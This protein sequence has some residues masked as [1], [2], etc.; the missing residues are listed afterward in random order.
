M[1]VAS[2]PL[3]ISLFGGS[4]DNP[5]F[6]KKYGYG[7]VISF[8][9]NLKTYISLHKDMLGYN[10]YG[11]KFIVNYSKREEID[12]ISKI[13]N[14]PVRL[15]F[16]YFNIEPLTVSLNSDSYS[17]GSGLAS[18]SSYIISL[19]KAISL[20]KKIKMTPMEI[21]DLAYKLEL[22]IN[23]YCGYQDPYGCGIGGLKRIEF[24]NDKSIKYEFLETNFFNYYDAHLIFTGV[25]RNSR[26]VLKDISENIEKS[27]PLLDTLEQAYSEFKKENFDKF[28]ELLN[29]SWIQK[30]NTSEIISSNDIIKEMDKEIT[31]NNS[32][33][34]HKLCGAG[35]GGFFL[36]F[37][38]KNKLNI[39]FDKVKISVAT[40][41]VRG[42][43][44]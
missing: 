27:K 18:S 9:S 35:N 21:C 24:F 33:I 29:V 30:K 10:V 39:P 23:P 7:S 26:N 44:L 28:L 31:N 14:D 34:A 5:F 32:I 42:H 4:T 22:Q 17:Q 16:E 20:Y 12:S 41:G 40:D 37:S 25:T 2:C 43:T 11:G 1:Y 15:V 3:R 19:I 38:E 13:I 8:A 6:V 36:V